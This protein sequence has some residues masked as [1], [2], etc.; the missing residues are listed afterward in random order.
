MSQI[1]EY[2]LGGIHK[3]IEKQQ[4]VPVA[5]FTGTQKYVLQMAIYLRFF[6]HIIQNHTL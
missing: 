1:Q 2:F 3:K 6:L 5:E 4:A